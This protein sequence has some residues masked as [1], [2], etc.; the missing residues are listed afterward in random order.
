MIQRS[1]DIQTVSVRAQKLRLASK[2]T[3]EHTCGFWILDF[4][5]SQYLQ[6]STHLQSYTSRIFFH[7]KL[8]HSR[9][10]PTH[11][12]SHL[13][14]AERH[15]TPFKNTPKGHRSISITTNTLS[16]IP[17]AEQIKRILQHLYTTGADILRLS[18]QP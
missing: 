12:A 15:P 4:Q 1:K 8:S 2:S 18:F 5:I 11:A 17:S 10:S 13:L 7:V 6:A 9:K 16:L 3:N 14:A